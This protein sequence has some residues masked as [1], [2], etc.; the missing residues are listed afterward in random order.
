M[1]MVRKCPFCGRDV[2]AVQDGYYMAPVIRHA[3]AGPEC[4]FRALVMY[5]MDMDTAVMLWNR[6]QRMTD[7]GMTGDD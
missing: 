5:G 7:G 6:R 2:K 3:T 4:V 1:S